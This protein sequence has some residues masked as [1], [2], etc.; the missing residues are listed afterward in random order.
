VA[1]NDLAAVV[2]KKLMASLSIMKFFLLPRTNGAAD[3][4]VMN[5]L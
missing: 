4:G 3:G 5:H 1:N 2:L